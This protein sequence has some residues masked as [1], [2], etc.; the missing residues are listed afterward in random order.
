[1]SNNLSA[2]IKLL[3]KE[4]GLTLE[5][6]ASVVGVQKSTVRKWETGMITS[7]KQ[8]KIANLAKA[9]GTTTAYLM[10][11][12]TKED[13]DAKLAPPLTE[14]EKA[15]LGLFNNAS[16]NDQQTILRLIS[17]FLDI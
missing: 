3:R 13:A 12:E 17:A 1:M 14:N 8:D 6:V 11:M 5:Q 7:M 2:K 9:L 16:K 4:K 15:L 10:D